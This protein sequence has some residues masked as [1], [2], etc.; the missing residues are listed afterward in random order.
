MLTTEDWTY[1][2]TGHMTMA[3]EQTYRSNQIKLLFLLFLQE[4]DNYN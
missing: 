4:T 3:N 1:D 2:R